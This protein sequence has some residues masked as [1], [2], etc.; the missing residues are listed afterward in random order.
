MA[1][2][3]IV[4]AVDEEVQYGM[5]LPG[6]DRQD[7]ATVFGNAYANVDDV[8]EVAWDRLRDDWLR[9]KESISESRHTRRSYEHATSAWFEFLS[10]QLKPDG[11]AVKKWEVTTAHVR[12]WQQ[13]LLNGQG[14]APSSINQRMAAV[15]SLYTFVINEKVM[16]NGWEISAFV[17]AGWRTRDNPFAR[18]G[19]IK[20]S[21][22]KPYEKVRVLSGKECS[23]LMNYL[24]SKS[25]TWTG[26]RNYALILC[27]LLTGYRNSEV[28]EMTWGKIRPNRDKPKNL[29]YE[30]KGKGGKTNADPLPERCYCAIVH[31]LKLDG[32]RPEDM[33]PE[34][35]IFRPMI[36]HNMK[37][38]RNYKGPAP[39]IS[40]S[41]AE[42][43]LHAALKHAGVENPTQMRVHDLR[44]TF[45]QRFHK[46]NTDVEALRI[47]LHH[48]SLATTQIYLQSAI[49]E[50]VDDY[51]EGIYQTLKFDF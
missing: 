10:T 24:E 50:P 26:S 42:T 33:Q 23:A 48:E 22:S 37:N 35:F 43:I 41:Q 9:L 17:D 40:G 25:H 18:G 31:Y 13:H 14:L 21:K 30:W 1:E 45:A 19:N 3:E 5:V 11:K 38:L 4:Q 47:R 12:G 34:D 29:I 28:T 46:N 32:R 16:V 7:F 2:V 8:L 6:P 20:R 27:Y 49:G 36:T 39:H 15:S 51:S 44:H